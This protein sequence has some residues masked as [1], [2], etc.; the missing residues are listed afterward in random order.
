MPKTTESGILVTLKAW[1]PANHKDL[2]EFARKSLA[3]MTAIPSFDGLGADE[4][5]LIESTATP[6][7]RRAI[8]QAP[9]PSASAVAGAPV[10]DGAEGSPPSSAPP[11]A[12]DLTVPE[13]LR[14]LPR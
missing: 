11:A 2:R 14:R 3:C 10:S 1:V 7:Q 6:I 12:L 4:W 8:E 9:A 5:Q 13:N